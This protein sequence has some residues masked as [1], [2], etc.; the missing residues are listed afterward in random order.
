MAV[1]ASLVVLQSQ[2]PTPG[3]GPAELV[4]YLPLL[5]RIGWFLLGF[6]TVV[7]VGLFVVEPFVSR[8]VRR[9]NRN[10]P[11]IQDAL[12]RYVRLL[13]FLIAVLA[14]VGLAGYGGLL[15]D[16]ALVVAAG[17]LAVGVAAQTVIGSL[18]S[19]LV[20]VLDPEFSVGNYVEWNEYEGT[21]R[22]IELRTTR[23]Q[24]PDGGLVTIPNTMLTS[25]P[26]NRPYGRD[27]FR[28]V[29]RIGIDYEDDVEEALRLCTETTAAVDG[30]RTAP[31][32]NA[33]VDEIG[34]DAIILRVHYWIEDPHP[35]QIFDVRSA[36]AKAVVERLESAG[37]EISP[38]PEQEI[39][40]RISVDDGS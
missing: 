31:S 8:V 9:R 30:I 33:Y 19:G 10:N 26:V 32:P 34:D 11:T 2:T 13:L 39:R 36:Y 40:G 25:Q 17:T 35:S 14:G 12:T 38:P 28:I 7:V 24:T 22:S 4:D 16:S 37:I 5:R 3:T 21:I 1:P 23:L 6:V 15:S 27:R 29:Q 18:V 20:L